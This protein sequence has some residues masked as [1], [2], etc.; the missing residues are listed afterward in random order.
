[1]TGVT[2]EKTR[3]AVS[4]GAELLTKSHCVELGR[5]LGLLVRGVVLV[6]QVLAGS[7]VDSPDRSLER[8]LG[9]GLVTLGDGSL[10]LLDRGLHRALLGLVLGVAGLGQLVAF[11][12]RFDVGHGIRTSSILNCIVKY[13]VIRHGIYELTEIYISNNVRKMQAFF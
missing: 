2:I 8:D 6:D 11:R 5:H 1:M 4:D 10:E 3:P 9:T 12:G 7:L 13:T